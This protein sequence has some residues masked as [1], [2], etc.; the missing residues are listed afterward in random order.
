MFLIRDMACNHYSDKDMFVSFWKTYV[1]DL[2]L[3]MPLL[4]FTNMT[5]KEKNENAII[6]KCYA[7]W[8]ISIWC[9]ERND[10]RLCPLVIWT[11]SVWVNYWLS[12]E[13]VI[14]LAIK[15]DWLCCTRPCWLQPTCGGSQ[16]TPMAEKYVL[17]CDPENT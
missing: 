16:P 6:M 11:L 9:K 7:K 8:E 14:W 10:F 2:S 12:M 1:Y 15:W 17:W 13:N 3:L 5:F 4:I